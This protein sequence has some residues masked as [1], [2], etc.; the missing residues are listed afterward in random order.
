[1]DPNEKIILNIREDIPTK[2]IEVNIEPT[3][4]AHEESLFFDTTH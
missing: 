1:M 2:S 3:G 4:V